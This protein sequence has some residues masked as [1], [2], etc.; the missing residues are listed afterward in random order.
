MTLKKEKILINAVNISAY[1][2]D[3]YRSDNERKYI[4]Q[5]N[6]SLYRFHLYGNKLLDITKFINQI[7]MLIF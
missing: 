7:K 2:N 3:H 5:V 6:P 4:H 1:E